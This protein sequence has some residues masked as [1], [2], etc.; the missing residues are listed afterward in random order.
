MSPQRSSPANEEF[1]VNE[2][3]LTWVRRVREGDKDAFVEMFDW[4]APKL[5]GFVNAHVFSR[6]IAEEIVQ[7]LFLGVWVNRLVWDVP[8]PLRMYL[9]RAALNRIANHRRGLRRELS[10]HSAMREHQSV[11][12]ETTDTNAPDAQVTSRELR[13]SIESAV[14]A[15]PDKCR[16]VWLLSREHYMTYAE[17]ASLLDISVKTVELHMHRAFRTLRARLKGWRS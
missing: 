8:G 10:L 13:R 4:Y 7:D 15:L 3:D 6:D 1:P 17:I 11:I 12:E 16:Q 9:Y 14:A 2:R 5:C